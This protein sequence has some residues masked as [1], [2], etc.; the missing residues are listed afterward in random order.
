MDVNSSPAKALPLSKRGQKTRAS[1]LRAARV[2]FERDGYIDSKISDI[3]REAGA[4][5]GS[6]YTYF[7]DKRDI[8]MAML[9]E[10]EQSMLYPDLEAIE[11]SNDPTERIRASNHRY[12]TSY[13]DQAGLMRLLEQVA[14]LDDEFLAMRRRRGEAFIRRN[15]KGILRLQAAG[16]ADPELDA[17]LISMALSSMVSRVAHAAF[18]IGSTTT[19][20]DDLVDTV[21]SIWVKVLGLQAVP[22]R[23]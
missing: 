19:D 7:T 6:F 20:I 18:V 8:F 15:A 14:T 22:K 2:V 13:R 5:N 9:E 10:A 17:D 1:L 3:P 11:N 4:A 16:T 21:T 12:L 23:S